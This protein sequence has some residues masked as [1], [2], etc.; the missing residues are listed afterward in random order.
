MCASY[1]SLYGDF[2]HYSSWLILKDKQKFQGGILPISV[3]AKRTKNTT[4]GD[5][6]SSD[7]GAPPMD[8]NQPMYEDESSG[9]PLSSRC[10][11]GSKTAKN[12]GKAKATSSQNPAPAPTPTL[13]ATL[14]PASSSAAGHS[15]AE[16]VAAATRRMLLDTHHAFRQCEDPGEAEYHKWLIDDLRRKLGMMQ[17]ML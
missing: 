1:I 10:P 8:L 2:K 14:A 4:A 13:I 11:I 3:V 15:Y 9:T 6:K 16:L 12:K 17:S 5:Y 7:S